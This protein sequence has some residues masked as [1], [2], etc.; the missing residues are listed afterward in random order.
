MS[1]ISQVKMWRLSDT[2]SFSRVTQLPK[3]RQE[4]VPSQDGTPEFLF[5]QRRKGSE[6]TQSQKPEG[7]A[8]SR[9]PRLY[10]YLQRL[11]AHGDAC[12]QHAVRDAQAVHVQ[13]ER[14]HQSHIRG[15]RPLPEKIQSPRFG[16]SANIVEDKVNPGE[17]EPHQNVLVSLYP[18]LLAAFTPS[19]S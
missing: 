13:E 7:P 14:G 12:L 2:E 10:S 16:R 8:G 4:F 9:Q 5:S 11:R 17:E 1:R 6:E 15:S 19:T 3:G 18:G